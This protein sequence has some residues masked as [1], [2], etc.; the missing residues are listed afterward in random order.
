MNCT[1]VA[2]GLG[3]TPTDKL[4]KSSVSPS[5]I[6][7]YIYYRV[8]QNTNEKHTEQLFIVLKHDILH[9]KWKVFEKYLVRKICGKKNLW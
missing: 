7:I 9:Y 5:R 6:Y 4:M 8:R 3:V 1:L 2:R